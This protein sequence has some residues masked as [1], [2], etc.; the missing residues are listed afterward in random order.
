MLVFG[1]ASST[2]WVLNPLLLGGDATNKQL[3]LVAW[4]GL[5]TSDSPI[6]EMLYVSQCLVIFYCFLASW[7]LDLF[8]ASVMIHIAALLK[9]VSIRFSLV[10]ASTN[11]SNPDTQVHQQNKTLAAPEDNH[12]MVMM[13]VTRAEYMHQHCIIN[14]GFLFRFVR[15]LENIV[16]PLI[17]TQFLAGIVVICVNLYHTT[18]ATNGLLWASKFATYL[19]MLVFQIFIYCWCAH[20]IVEQGQLVAD[21]ALSVGWPDAPP[22]VQRALLFVAVRAQRR[23]AI[24]AGRL[25]PVTRD[26]FLASE[27]VGEAAYCSDWPYGSGRYKS[28]LRLMMWRSQRPITTTAGKIY[29]I[30]RNIFAS[31]LRTVKK[32]YF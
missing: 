27:R 6:Y 8:L 5:G 24:T 29:A 22:T 26:S 14:T 10:T 12:E 2:G 9:I 19:L 21:A 18:T 30:D 32:I 23:L 15:D 28:A 4:Y 3:P 20:D 1:V 17:L 16:S 13:E 25:Q 31:F 11:Y 7:G